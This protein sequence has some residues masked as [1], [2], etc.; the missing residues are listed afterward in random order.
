MAKD[1]P[2][3]ECVYDE[4]YSP[5]HGTPPLPVA[6]DDSVS[7]RWDKSLGVLCQ[8]F[9]M[10]FLVIPVSDTASYNLVSNNL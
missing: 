1:D 2:D 6:G 8:K 4:D 3:F 7:S 5:S 10:L 9:V